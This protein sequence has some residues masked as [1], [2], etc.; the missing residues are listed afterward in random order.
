MQISGRVPID[1]ARA[2]VVA[3]LFS[4]CATEVGRSPHPP[5]ESPAHSVNGSRHPPN[6]PCQER[7]SSASEPGRL[8]GRVLLD[9]KPVVYYGVSIVRNV[10]LPIVTS[11]VSISKQC[12]NV[13]YFDAK[14]RGTRHCDR[15]TP[16]RSAGGSRSASAS[17]RPAEFRRFTRQQGIHGRGSRD[18]RDATSDRI[19]ASIYLAFRSF[20]REPVD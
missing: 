1:I 14:Q 10:A 7:A 11:P 16:L 8:S 13:R 3:A 4:A 6:S 5:A 2:V 17:L 15:W 19:R 12:G 20:F 18:R 9:G